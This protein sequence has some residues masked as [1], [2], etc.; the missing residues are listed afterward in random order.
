M[1][2]YIKAWKK[3]AVFSGRAGREEYW[4]FVLFNILAN[5]LLTIIA[6]VVSAEVGFGLLGLYALAVLIPGLAVSIRRLHDTNRS[7]WWLLVSLIPVIGPFVL[8]FFMLQ[9]SQPDENQYGAIPTT[10]TA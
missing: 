4:Y 8:L 5:I 9:G 1:N 3:Y 10:A 6:G 7:G 2:W